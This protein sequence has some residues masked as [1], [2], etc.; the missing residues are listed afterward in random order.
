MNPENQV[1]SSEQEKMTDEQIKRHEETIIAFYKRQSQILKL[2]KDYETLLADIED[3]RLRRI[4]AT[5]TIAAITA[6]PEKPSEQ[7]EQQE[8]RG[9]EEVRERPIRIL[10][11][12]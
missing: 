5:Y 8:D 4:K 1:L 3:A 9:S 12:D 7:E 11:K 6:G 2:Q 10:R